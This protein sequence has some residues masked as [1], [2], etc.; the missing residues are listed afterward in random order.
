MEADLPLAW[1][2]SRISSMARAQY[3]RLRFAD[4]TRETIP[5][6]SN[7]SIV[8]PRRR[9]RNVHLLCD[10]AHGP[11]RVS[12]EEAQHLLR[13]ARLGPGQFLLPALMQIVDVLDA[14][15]CIFGLGAHTSQEVDEP[16]LPGP[17]LSD[18]RADARSIPRAPPRTRRSDREGAKKSTSRTTRRRVTRRRPMRPLPSRNGWIASNCACAERGVHE[19]RKFLVVE[20]PLQCIQTPHQLIDRRGHVGRIAQSCTPVVQSSSGCAGTLRASQCPHVRRA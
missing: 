6:S 13:P 1:G 8:P 10:P 20:E 12:N 3:T 4:P 15:K 5:A 11:E 9:V 17:I 16:G 14:G 18:S 19:R 2:A 7:R